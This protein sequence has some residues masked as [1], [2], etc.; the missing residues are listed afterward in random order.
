MNN[1]K[2]PLKLTTPETFEGYKVNKPNDQTGE[3]V[4]KEIADELLEACQW[5][6]EQ[7]KRLADEGHY[8]EFMLQQNGGEGV[9]PLVKA[10]NNA[11]K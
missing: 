1:C 5:A 6:I 8:P 7:F 3:Y 4:D 2:T 10:I 11:T 9:M